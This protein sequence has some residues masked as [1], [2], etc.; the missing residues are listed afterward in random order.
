MKS[1]NR[2]ILK[3]SYVLCLVLEEYVILVK[4]LL[5]IGQLPERTVLCTTDI[6]GLD[7]NISLDEGLAFINN[8]LD[9]R[10]DKQVTAD[11]LIELAALVL[12]NNIFEF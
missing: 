4:Y 6:F 8:F 5:V 10:F 9:S 3:N 2:N 11:T 7:P 1:Y 12:K